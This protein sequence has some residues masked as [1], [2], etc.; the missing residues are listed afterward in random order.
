MAEKKEIDRDALVLNLARMIWESGLTIGEFFDALQMNPDH[1]LMTEIS[2][3][4]TGWN[5]PNT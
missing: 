5:N 4:F 1:D 2:G 3:I